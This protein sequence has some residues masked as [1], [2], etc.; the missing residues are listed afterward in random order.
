[1]I[2]LLW[3]YYPSIPKSYMVRKFIR[4]ESNLR[5]FIRLESNYIVAPLG[6][7]SSFLAGRTQK[8]KIGSIFSSL[9]FV[10]VGVPQ[11]SVL[12]PILFL[13]FFN[14]ILDLPLKALPV[15]FPD[16]IACGYIKCK[17]PTMNRQA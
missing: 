4:I 9:Y 16:D 5:N 14:S 8:V 6:W 7:F 1:M 11:G 3:Q 2:W 13:I 17:K 12:G 10:T 15:A